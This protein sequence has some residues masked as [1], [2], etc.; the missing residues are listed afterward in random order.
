MKPEKYIANFD[1]ASGML[2][3]LG[4]FLDGKDFPA[5]AVAPP[6]EAL[7]AAVNMLPQRLREQVYIWSGWGESVPA[8]RLD[9]VQAE[10]ISRWATDHYPERLYPGAMIGSAS[11]ALIHLCAALQIPWLPQTTFVAVRQPKIH[12]DDVSEAAEWGVKPGRLLL[13]A[14]PE[15][16]LHHMHDAN[17]DRLMVRR[18]TYFRVKR[19]RLGEAYARWLK[20]HV[21][22]GGTIFVARSTRTFPTTRLGERHLFQPGALGGATE[23]EFLHG[24]PR[25]AEYLHRYGSH[26]RKWD[27]PEVDGESPEAEWGF[28]D[29]LLEDI[30]QFAESNGYKLRQIVYEEP[31][32]P[33][34]LVADLY[35]R[36]N[37]RR[38]VPD[39]RLIAESFIMMEPYWVLR[40]GSIPYWMKFN[41]DPSLE[42]LEAYLDGADPFDFIHVMLFSHGVEAVGLP[43][44]ERWKQAAQRARLHGELL[45]VDEKRFPRDYATFV[46]Y[47]TRLKR[48]I[49]D[50]YPM[51]GP[52]SIARLDE[53]LAE[54]GDRYP[55][56]W[57]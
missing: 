42:W 2:R 49:P 44:V 52:L 36:W 39:R 25:V 38:N 12:P 53:F 32:H 41:M 11:G 28:E 13:D 30:E 10:D 37:R 21:E 51:P 35:R 19:L 15:L 4:R 3:A 1:S 55:V 24:G 26:R 57:K 27:P 18:M 29:A 34:P 8:K 33:S 56:H 54:A 22:P 50:R 23:E 9:K 17:Q 14:N 5:L 7:G 43:R 16:Q 40:T 20:E 47:Y 46:R 6:V 48:N 45:G 31:E